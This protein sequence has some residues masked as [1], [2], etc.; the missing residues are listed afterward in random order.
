V[1]LVI[2]EPTDPVVRRVAELLQTRGA[3]LARLDAGQAASYTLHGSSGD[4]RA[5]RPWRLVGGGCRGDRAV[6]AVFVRRGALSRGARGA[7]AQLVARVDSMLLHT[8]CTVINRPSMTAG[9]YAKVHQLHALAAAG[10]SVPRTLV[11]SVAEAALRFIATHQGRVLVKGLS[12]IKSIPTAV[13]PDHLQR[14]HELALC[15]VQL[16]EIID[17]VDVRLTVIGHRISTIVTSPD[18]AIRPTD[19]ASH[20][21]PAL[22]NRCIQFTTHAGLILSGFDV[23]LDPRGGE[24]VLEMNT[25]PLVTHYESAINPTISNSLCDELLASRS[26]SSDI[27]V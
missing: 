21:S 25:N 19:A 24:W 5:G 18:G 26:E 2:G 8:G 17:G 27:L 7:S 20:L 3:A 11:T 9:N 23:R 10:F 1:I 4:A 13:G 14:L 6:Q 16:Q 22:L 15:P 12:S